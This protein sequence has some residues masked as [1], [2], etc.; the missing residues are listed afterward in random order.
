MNEESAIVIR[1]DMQYIF[2]EYNV[3]M[4]FSLKMNFP[5]A[6]LFCSNQ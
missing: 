2:E 4:T 5:L 3:I 6:F 1:V